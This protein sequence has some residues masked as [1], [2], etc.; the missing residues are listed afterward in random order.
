MLGAINCSPE[1]ASVSDYLAAQ[2]RAAAQAIRE[3]MARGLAEGEVGAHTDIDAL[4]GFYASVLKGMSLSAHDG[5][6]RHELHRFV[7]C[8]MAAWDGFAAADR[9]KGA[10]PSAVSTIACPPSAPVA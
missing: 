5:A 3:R 8:A 9:A 4:A 6:R 2:R 10:D 1:N 7:D